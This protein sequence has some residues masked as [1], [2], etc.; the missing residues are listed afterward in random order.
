MNKFKFFLC[1]SSL[2]IFT[3][4]GIV[5]IAAPDVEF[6][7]DE[8]RILQPLPEIDGKA[9][10]DGDFQLQMND[11][12][13][14]RAAFR[15]E[16]MRIYAFSQKLMGKSEYNGVYVCDDD[17]IIEVYNEPENTV[18]ICDKFNKAAEKTGLSCSLM[19]IPTAV[20]IYD[21]VLPPNVSF[22][23]TQRDVCDYFYSNTE[24]NCIDLW[25]T[26]EN[27]RNDVQLYYKTDHHWTTDAAYLAYKEYCS[28]LS[29]E[30]LDKSDFD[31]EIVSDKFL[32]TTYS[33][34]LSAFPSYDE[35]VAFKQDMTGITVTY[36]QGEGELYADEFLEKKD[37]YS[38]FLNS[39]QS[40]VI[41]E[42]ENVDNGRVLLIV[43]DSYAN[44]LVPFL[45]NHFEKTVVLDT[46]YYRNGASFAAEECGATDILFCFNLNTLDTDT[47]IAGIY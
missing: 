24:M 30:P 23:T 35:I 7:E 31:I 2:A 34:A 40:Q 14:D 20:S 3:L 28:T 39:N 33:K 26:F 10:V 46:R 27:N 12:L 42:N 47:A 9:I 21:D 43:K 19:L 1:A 4:G 38:Y 45:M 6:S 25:D 8:N 17:W 44:C 15:N 41:I 11:Y 16:F 37:K 22:K 32:G 18:Q 13:T 5:S 29:F 36:P